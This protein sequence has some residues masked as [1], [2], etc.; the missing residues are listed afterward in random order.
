M[1][2]YATTETSDDPAA[3]SGADRRGRTQSDFDGEET[4]VQPANHHPLAG[5]NLSHLRSERRFHS[6]E[7]QAREELKTSSEFSKL[8]HLKV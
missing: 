6:E 5:W 8:C 3:I 4:R 7:N 2:H 1:R